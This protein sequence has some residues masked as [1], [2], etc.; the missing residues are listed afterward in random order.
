M[1]LDGYQHPRTCYFAQCKLFSSSNGLLL[2]EGDNI[3]IYILVTPQA[4]YEWGKVIGVSIHINMYTLYVGIA[5][6]APPTN[7]NFQI[8]FLLSRILEA[9]YETYLY[10]AS[11]LKSTITF[12]A[13]VSWRKSVYGGR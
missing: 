1:W 11:N 3:Y 6:P 12:L 13:S 4:Q 8:T 10:R 7:T 5:H 2:K 9:L